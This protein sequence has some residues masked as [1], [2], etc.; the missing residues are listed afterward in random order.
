[1]TEPSL[2]DLRTLERVDFD[3][4]FEAID[5]LPSATDEENSDEENTAVDPGTTTTAFGNVESSE[6]RS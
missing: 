4:R 3:D 5:P 2:D 1:M 6:G